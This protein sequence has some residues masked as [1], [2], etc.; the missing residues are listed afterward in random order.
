[1]ADD[2]NDAEAACADTIKGQTRRLRPG[3]SSPGRAPDGIA[4]L[5]E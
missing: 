4:R 3:Q 5:R 2:P 1:M